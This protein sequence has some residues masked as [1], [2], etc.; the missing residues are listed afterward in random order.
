MLKVDHIESRY[1]EVVGLHDISLEVNEG[2]IVALLGVNG[3]GKS[4]TLKTISGLLHPTKGTI[5]YLGERIDRLP[6]EIIVR[7]GIVHVPEGRRIFPGLTV[8]E[9]LIMGTSNRKVSKAEVEQ[10]IERVLAI[11]PDLKRLMNQ[12]GWSLSGGQQQMLAIGRGL[13]ANPKILM[14]DEP[15]L[16]LAPVIVKQVFQTIREI[17]EQGVTV[18]LVEQN[19]SMSLRI[20]HRA[21][22]LETGR[23]V[24]TDTAANLLADDAVRTTLLTAH[25]RG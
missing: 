19:A 22:L 7:K 1:G 2:E 8:K 9:N 16:G 5:E 17:N 24:R 10:G 23:V 3:A 25:G 4:T 20:A 11:F 21:Y 12:L 6:P 14:L 15:S 18:L 13:M